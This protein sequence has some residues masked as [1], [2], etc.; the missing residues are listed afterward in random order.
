MSSLVAERARPC[1]V[2]ASHERAIAPSRMRNSDWICSRCANRQ[3]T[4]DEA[5]YLAGKLAST[6]RKHGVRAPYPGTQLARVVHKRCRGRSVL[7]GERRLQRLCVVRVDPQRPWTSD[8]AVLVTSGEAYALRRASSASS[9]MRE[10]LQRA[11][12][13]AQ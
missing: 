8:N 13:S 5:R 6:L 1:R 7:S 2:C 12:G 4:G 10:L 9:W 11:S 3:R